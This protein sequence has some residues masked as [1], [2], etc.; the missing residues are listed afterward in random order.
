MRIERPIFH[1]FVVAAVIFVA[2]VSFAAVNE[3]RAEAAIEAQAEAVMEAPIEEG[4]PAAVETKSAEG[5]IL[6]QDRYRYVRCNSTLN[7]RRTCETGGKN[8]VRLWR[9]HSVSGCVKRR[10]WN[11]TNGGRFVWVNNGC[12]ATFQVRVR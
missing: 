2:V 3:L 8:P 9:R 1:F 7:R 4:A 12:Q 6:S 11:T 5:A 10:D